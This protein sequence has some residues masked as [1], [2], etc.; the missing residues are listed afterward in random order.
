MD[1]LTFYFPSAQ[2]TLFAKWWRRSRSVRREYD[3]FGPIRRFGTECVAKAEQNDPEIESH[4]ISQESLDVIQ[5]IVLKRLK[6]LEND[7]HAPCLTGA[8]VQTVSCILLASALS[9]RAEAPAAGH[10]EGSIQI[11]GRELKVVVDLGQ[12]AGGAWIGSITVPGLL[13]KGAELNEISAKDSGVAFAIKDALAAQRVGPAKFKGQMIS[14]GELAGN[15]LQAGNSAVFRL[16]KTGPPQVEL[17]VRSTAVGKEIEGEWKGDYDMMGYTRHVTIK[18][19][20]RGAEGATADFVVIGKKTNNLPVDLVTQEEGFLD[21]ESHA[22]GWATK[23][24]LINNPVNSKASSNKDR[25]KC[26]SISVAPI[27]L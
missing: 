14:A 21:V 1:P 24:G 6:T 17:P 9:S 25:S 22:T 15:F 19:T 11:P 27:S 26:R 7:W 10:W 18:I 2:C 4:V 3:R 12:D 8:D 5:S 23:A 13:V 20:N 16:A